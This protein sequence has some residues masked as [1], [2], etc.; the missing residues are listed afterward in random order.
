VFQSNF[1]PETFDLLVYRDLEA[2][3]KGHSRS[4]E[5]TLIDPPPLISC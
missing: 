4:S 3:V 1:V 5:P 2:Q